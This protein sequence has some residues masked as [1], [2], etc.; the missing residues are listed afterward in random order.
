[1]S[2]NKLETSINPKPLMTAFMDLS[3]QQINFEKDQHHKVYD[4][5]VWLE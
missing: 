5:I 3:Q 4:Y 2:L 1:M